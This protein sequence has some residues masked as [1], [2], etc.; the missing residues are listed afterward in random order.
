MQLFSKPLNLS[1]IIDMQ[2][3]DWITCYYNNT[4]YLQI[5][6]EYF[7][8]N[9]YLSEHSQYLKQQSTEKQKRQDIRT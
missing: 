9:H 6:V 3:K 7:I 4:C 5:L 1:L 8:S 2:Q